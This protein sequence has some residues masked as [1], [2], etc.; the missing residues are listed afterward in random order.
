MQECSELGI[1]GRNIPGELAQLQQQ[2]PGLFQDALAD[3]NSPTIT[4]AMD[5]YAAVTAYAHS[6]TPG[7]AAPDPSQTFTADPNQSPLADPGQLLPH[8][9]AI[10]SSN[11]TQQL[12]ANP[13]D[14]ANGAE[15]ES[16]SAGGDNQQIRWDITEE[17][18]DA[19]NGGGADIDWDVAV[20]PGSDIAGT[21]C[22]VP[23]LLCW[24]AVSASALKPEDGNLALHVI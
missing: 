10:R 18:V 14:A 5:H 11:Q 9:H 21:A 12:A 16:V 3:I 17:A 7:A 19:A 8:L 20:D 24:T 1:K 2:L 23:G 22:C 15:D 13:S 6:P 4:S